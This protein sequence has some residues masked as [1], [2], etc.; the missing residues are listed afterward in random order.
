MRRLSL[1]MIATGFVQA[2]LS[3]TPCTREIHRHLCYSCPI[4]MNQKCKPHHS[5]MLDPNLRVP[6]TIW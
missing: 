3:H 6:T 1:A 5:T 4:L 2:L